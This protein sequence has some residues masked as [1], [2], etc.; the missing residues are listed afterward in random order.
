A[1]LAARAALGEI[2]GGALSPAPSAVGDWWRLHV[3]TWHPLGTGTDVPAPA[4]VPLFALL[5]TVLGGPGV[6]V[7]AT[8]LL[9]VP[10]TLWGAWRFLRVV[11]R[12]VDPAGLPPWVLVW[13]AATYALVPATSGAWGEGRFGTV[14][15]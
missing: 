6:V 3:E 5:G 14:V 13:G 2:Q 9:A 12:L 15:L 1:L 10:F 8:M 4:Y 11:G 7:S